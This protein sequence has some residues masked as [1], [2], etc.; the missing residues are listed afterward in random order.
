MY[1]NL[2]VHTD[3]AYFILQLKLYESSS[4]QYLKDIQVFKIYLKIICYIW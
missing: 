1:L 2:E 3:G 4:A